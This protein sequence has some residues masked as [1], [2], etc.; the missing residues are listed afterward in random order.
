VLVA[1]LCFST[2]G[3]S[4]ALADVN[5]S[6]AAVGLSRLVVGG[7][8]LASW[9]LLTRSRSNVT[10]TRSDDDPMTRSQRHVSSALAALPVG[11][12]VALGASGV[13]AYQPAFFA[14][15]A[16]NG[17]G[18]GTVVALGSAP[19]IA[20]LVDSAIY[21][22]RP[23]LQWLVATALALVGLSLVAGLA[24]DQPRDPVGLAWSVLAGASYT[25]YAVAGKELID[26]GWLSRSAMGVMFGA[27][28]VAALPLLAA[29]S[30][31]WLLT[32]SGL[33][34]ALWLGVVTTALAYLS[35]GWG[36]QRLPFATV[37]T[38]TLAE[39]LCAALLGALLLDERLSALGVVGLGTL[40]AGLAV[41][42]RTRA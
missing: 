40:V 31:R 19:I 23:T 11:I 33:G 6:P 35:F 28:A 20:G 2:T 24:S 42:G 34:L 39:P 5:G 38:L 4:Q 37:A 18:T 9:T 1:A 36:L 22:R 27:A 41:L 25:C 29:T 13:L 26:R 3:T 7:A 32:P 17:V 16:S 21:R 14:G 30:P 12:L 8:L 10:V 15:T